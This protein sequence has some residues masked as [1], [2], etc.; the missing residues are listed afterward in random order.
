MSTF[1]EQ[2]SNILKSNTTKAQKTQA[3]IKLGITKYEAEYIAENWRGETFSFTFGVEIETVG[4]RFAEFTRAARAN[5]LSVYGSYNYNHTDM[6]QF[7]LVPDSSIRGTDAAECVTPPLD[8][9]NGGYESLRACCKA[10]AE[11]G[12]TANRSCGL[13][14]HIGAADMTDRHYCNVF[15]NYLWLE[16]AIES[17]LA[18]SRRGANATWCASL[19]NHQDA[20]LTA[21]TKNEMYRAL[22]GDR[23]HR[24]NPCAYSRH[25][26]IEFRQHQGSTN[27]TKIEAWVKFLGKLVEWSKDHRLYEAIDRIEDIPFLAD[28]EKAYFI[29]RRADFAAN[30]AR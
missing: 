1:N 3:L 30:T 20:V 28:D 25:R 24:V 6:Q 18:P 23:Y 7:K 12:A 5:G 9:S 14:V 13:H 2:I 22:N 8:S 11:V 26:T 10:L 21:T 19:R 15:A 4:C 27:F 17:F 16:K 29:G